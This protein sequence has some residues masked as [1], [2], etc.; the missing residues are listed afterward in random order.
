[1]AESIVSDSNRLLLIRPSDRLMSISS[2]GC[3]SFNTTMCPDLVFSDS[4]SPLLAGDCSKC[5][6]YL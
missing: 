2:P 5:F 1:M 3:P 4:S 6:A